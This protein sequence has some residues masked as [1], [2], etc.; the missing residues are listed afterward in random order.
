MHVPVEK[1]K[2]RK[3]RK[4]CEKKDYRYVNKERIYHANEKFKCKIT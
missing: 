1:A 4:E 2:R 3:K